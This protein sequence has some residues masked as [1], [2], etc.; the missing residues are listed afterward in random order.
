MLL[1]NLLQASAPSAEEIAGKLN[2]TIRTTPPDQLLHQLGTHAIQFGLKVLAALL[3]YIIGAWIIKLV[4]KSLK[5]GFARRNTEKTLA[6]F[7]ESLV[8][9]GM[10]VL[11]IVISISTLGI[12]TTSIAA[13]LAAGGMAIGMALSGTVQNFAGGIMILVFKPFKAGDFI[14][15]Q[16]FSGTVT[17]VTIVSTRLLTTD[18]R[19]V[20]IPNGALSNGNINNISAM[21]L[22]RVDINVSFQYGTDIQAAKTALLEIIRS[23]PAVLDASTPGAADP[24]VSVM[25][26]GDHGV[27][28]VTRSWVNTADYW[29]AFFY[30]NENFYTQLPSKYG[31]S[32]PFNQLDVHIRN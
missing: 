21:S 7:T 8:T 20:I 24:F 17:D 23:C 14:E 28:M 11:L 9:I 31:L 4:R 13:L 15:A 19:S 16:G 26:L 30:L 3:I 12:N 1:I 22:R 10:W 32:F 6:S 18:N 2:E 29:N 25:N 27:S 5:K